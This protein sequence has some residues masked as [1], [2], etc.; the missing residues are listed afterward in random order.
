MKIIAIH[1]LNLQGWFRPGHFHMNHV[2]WKL[3]GFSP[4]GDAYP[5]VG[6]QL[7]STWGSEVRIESYHDKGCCTLPAQEPDFAAGDSA[8]IAAAMKDLQ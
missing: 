8:A 4:G 3:L 2:I 7:S 6:R 5:A 1:L